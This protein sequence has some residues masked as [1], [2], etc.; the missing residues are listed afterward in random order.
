MSGRARPG[1]VLTIT[2]HANPR[3]KAIKALTQAKYRKE[4]G[5]FL[6]EGLKLVTDALEKNWPVRTVIHQIDAMSQPAVANAAAMARARGADIL[7]VSAD[8]L[9]K[10]ARR[11]KA[12]WSSLRPSS[13][14]WRSRERTGRAG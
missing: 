3:I 6:V 2:S 14:V 7:A 9:G 11:E 13:A 4:S 1:Q 5:Q 12:R 10:I 8:I